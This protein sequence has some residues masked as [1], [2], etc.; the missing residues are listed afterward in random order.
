MP[1]IT[2][3]AVDRGELVGGHSASTE[4][5]IETNFEQFP[6]RRVHKGEFDETLDG[7][8]EGWLDA[9]QFEYDIVT[10]LILPAARA[11]WAEFFSSVAN[12]EQFQID[13]TGTIASPGTDVNVWLINDSLDEQQIV[14]IGYKY[15][16]Q[17]K[18][19]PS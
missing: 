9:I 5:Q 8:P 3:I 19:W 10:D 15:A 14:H 4:Y 11:N 16:F 18:R 13:F 17:V 12:R 7:T 1:V 6:R 2:Y